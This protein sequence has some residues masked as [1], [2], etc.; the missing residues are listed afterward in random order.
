MTDI[1]SAD[2]ERNTDVPE[3]QETIVGSARSDPNLRFTTLAH[4]LTPECLHR[5]YRR[6]RRN[7]APGSDGILVVEY[8]EELEA[9]V[10]E[11]H[12]Q[13][14]SGRYRTLPVRRVYIP[15]PNGGPSADRNRQRRGPP[16][17]DGDRE[18]AGADL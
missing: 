3:W 5:A 9:N 6:M 10:A 4:R 16:G 14:R 13:L 1:P 11:L 17:L 2:T 7:A 12:E 15:K 8:G 18:R